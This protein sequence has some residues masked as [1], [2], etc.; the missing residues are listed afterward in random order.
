MI[1]A[2]V[3][4]QFAGVSPC[5]TS[6]SCQR[7]YTDCRNSSLTSI[8]TNV[9]S[10]TST[11]D[12]SFNNI[13]I[14]KNQDL[15]ELPHLNLIFLNNNNISQLEPYVFHQTKNLLYLYLNN[16]KIIEINISLFQFSK[17][18]RYL[19]LQNNVIRYIHPRL[20]EHNS[21]LVMLDISGNNIH[22]IE[23]Q[24]FESN[25]IL[26]WVNIGGNP[27]TLPLEWNT[28][29]SD[30]F[31]V[32]D[33]DICGSSSSPVS[34][35]QNVPSLNFM[36]MN[37][38]NFLNLDEFTSLENILGLNNVERE[39]LKLKLFHRL[40]SSSYASI[41]TMKIGEDF[42]VVSLTEDAILCYCERQEFWYWCNGQS[43][44]TCQNI[45]T[46]TGIHKLLE[47]DVQ[48]HDVTS[49]PDNKFQDMTSGRGRNTRLFGQIH[50]PVNWKTIRNTLLYA[51]G[52]FCIIILV[53]SVKLVKIIRM[54]RS[55]GETTDSSIYLQLKTSD[56]V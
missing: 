19:Y 1:V 20:L 4:A 17:K 8:P 22:K 18:L 32:L 30:C 33:I 39:Y 48:T 31:N 6:C 51:A 27:L 50:R 14:L 3:L 54:R 29:F 56:H 2:L 53:I 46:K 21:D 40:Y 44:T 25:R 16:N 12:F 47:C 34:V 10:N 45:T 37:H 35:F 42:N 5:P 7:R 55:R 15:P 36:G 28:L 13:S 9:T 23:P 11:I 26:S 24:T 49:A 43:E 41:N 38:P 52:P